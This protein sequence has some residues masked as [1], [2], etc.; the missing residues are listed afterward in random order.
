MRSLRLHSLPAGPGLALCLAAS[1]PLSCGKLNLVEESR[2]ASPA[3]V[4]DSRRVLVTVNHTRRYERENF[5]ASGDLHQNDSRFFLIATDSPGVIRPLKTR[6]SGWRQYIPNAAGTA[7]L[8]D[9]RTVFDLEKD[10]LRVLPS[11]VRLLKADFRA[12]LPGEYLDLDW[13]R[14]TISADRSTDPGR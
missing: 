2:T 6:A 12:E 14:R 10:A 13:V 8:F 7:V 4:L 9:Y 1:G 5:F 11:A 3:V